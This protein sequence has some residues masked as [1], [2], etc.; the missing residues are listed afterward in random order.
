MAPVEAVRPPVLAM[1]GQLVGLLV[2]PLL[3][4][5]ALCRRREAFS[6]GIRPR[7]QRLVLAALVALVLWI[8]VDRAP[9]IGAELVPGA[10]T[11]SLFLVPAMA[12]GELLGRIARVAPAE[13]LAWVVELGFRNLGLA[14]VVTVT[15]LRQ[16][17]FL[18]FATVFFV[19]AVVYA[20]AV[21]AVFRRLR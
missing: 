5:M 3:A 9:D 12:V 13:R 10:M 4:G 14:V 1:I 7:L 11:A 2:L 6:R 15:L 17:G 20:L 18:A 16:E 19:T 8:L 21:V